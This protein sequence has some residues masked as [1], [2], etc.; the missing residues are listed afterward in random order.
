MRLKQL[1]GQTD[2]HEFQLL[3]HD[4]RVHTAEIATRFGIQQSRLSEFA[5]LLGIPTRREAGVCYKPTL[6]RVKSPVSRKPGSHGCNPDCVEWRRCRTGR[7]WVD[8]PL[9]CETLLKWE[10]EN[11]FDGDSSPSYWVVPLVVR[12]AVEAA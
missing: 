10:I 5:H 4:P 3:Y 8:G 9:P 6:L 12:V 1:A 2:A 11:E 7:L